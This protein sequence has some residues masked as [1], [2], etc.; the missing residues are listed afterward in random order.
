MRLRDFSY[1]TALV[2]S[3]LAFVGACSDPTSSGDD[4]DGNGNG[5]NGGDNGS[6]VQEGSGRAEITGAES[7]TLE[8]DA[9]WTYT[10]DIS[11]RGTRYAQFNVTVEGNDQDEALES[12]LFQAYDPETENRPDSP[13]DGTY[14]LGSS[15]DDNTVRFTNAGGTTYYFDGPST[16]D[17]TLTKDG[18]VWTLELDVTGLDDFDGNLVDVTATVKAV[19]EP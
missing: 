13:E 14:Q 17:L 6:E 19:P 3:A 10:T 16:G 2:V 9:T 5:G 11:S 15:M 8:G 7:L 1:R 18:A 4:G 12:R